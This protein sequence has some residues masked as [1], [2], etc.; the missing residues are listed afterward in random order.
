MSNILGVLV[1]YGIV[2]APTSTL[3]LK[4]KPG[5]AAL[6]FV[7]PVVGTVVGLVSLSRLARPNSWWARRRYGISQMQAARDRYPDA[8]RHPDK[9][10]PGIAF[11]VV[12]VFG[13][14]MVIVGLLATPA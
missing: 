2:F 3:L 14:G 10:L 5:I 13:P 7:I 12:F 9:V 1:V 6:Y 8:S 11:V 4:G